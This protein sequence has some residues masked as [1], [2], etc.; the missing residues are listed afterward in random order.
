MG[1][2]C[3]WLEG[4]VAFRAADA[5]AATMTRLRDNRFIKLSFGLDPAR[6]ASAGT[7]P[8]LSR[9]LYGCM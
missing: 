8:M 2:R 3:R 4:F 5:C 6:K 9:W 1:E 7:H